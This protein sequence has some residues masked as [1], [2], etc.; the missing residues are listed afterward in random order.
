M[1]SILIQMRNM[2]SKF[3]M[4]GIIPYLESMDKLVMESL[5]G[6]DYVS[7]AF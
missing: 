1:Q 4:T 6:E 2:T 5:Y 3:L 7:F